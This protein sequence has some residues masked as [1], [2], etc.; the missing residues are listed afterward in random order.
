VQ[1]GFSTSLHLIGKVTSITESGGVINERFPFEKHVAQ[2]YWNKIKV[3]SNLEFLLFEDRVSWIK[4]LEDDW[5]CDSNDS[6]TSDD[7]LSEKYETVSRTVIGN[8]KEIQ[9][10]ILVVDT[11]DQNIYIQLKDHP[12]L[13]WKFVAGDVVS[14]SPQISVDI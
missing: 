1:F 2:D 4:L 5:S 9:D 13:K 14:I 7:S 12:N 8:L 11:G 6:K 3:G 10:E